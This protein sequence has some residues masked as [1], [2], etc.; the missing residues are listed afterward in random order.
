[1]LTG[2]PLYDNVA[3]A[4]YFVVPREWDTLLRAIERDLNVLVVGRRGAGKTTL[5]HQALLALRNQKERVAF[6]DGTGVDDP[7]DLAA[8]IRTATQS[9]VA[10]TVS[11]LAIGSIAGTG[12]LEATDRIRRLQQD[13]S[14]LG[15]APATRILVDA[16]GSAE[17]AFGIFGRMRDTLWQFDHRWV[18]AA[19]EDD[20]ATVLKAPADA[21]FDT[22]VTLGDQS[23]ERLMSLLEKRAPDADP[24]MRVNVAARA[25]GNPRAAI[26]ALNRALV[27][28][29]DPESDFS[30]RA[31]LL[32]EAAS[33][34]R[35]HGMLM[36]ELLDLGGASP[37][38]QALL[39]R[40]GLSRARTTQL[41]RE[42]LNR[43]LVVAEIERAAGPG[44]PK[45]VYRPRLVSE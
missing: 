26:R 38:D 32:D 2:R 16:S 4:R 21:F 3:D 43:G 14:A 7:A 18:V 28:G 39:S 17:A 5:L 44:R 9:R 6:V 25:Q 45:T 15:D 27:H 8:R 41:L 19:D 11:G 40:L 20:R 1:M 22:V 34:G 36:A 35:P 31:E 29:L 13:L 10:R 23:T 30:E 42:L 37:S 12:Q 33:I 24:T